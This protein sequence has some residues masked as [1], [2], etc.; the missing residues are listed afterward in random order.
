[1][2]DENRYDLIVIGGGPGGYVGAIRAAQNGLKVACVEKRGRLGGTCLNVGCIRPRRCCSPVPSFEEARDHYAGPRDQTSGVKLDLKKMLGRKDNVVTD[3]TD[4]IEGSSRRTR[5]STSSARAR[6]I[7]NE[8]VEVAPGGRKK[9]QT[10]STD[11][12]LIA[13][14]SDVATIP[15]VEIDENRSSPPPARWNCRRCRRA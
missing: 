10:L 1:M 7:D 2:S 5:S 13:T 11:T 9:K 14:G 15:N 12:I 4:G 6:I 3:L 8:T